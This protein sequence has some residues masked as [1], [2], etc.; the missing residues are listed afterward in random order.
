MDKKTINKRLQEVRRLCEE[1]KNDEIYLRAM[2]LKKD[3][4]YLMVD[5]TALRQTLQDIKLTF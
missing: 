5:V 2:Y 1:I 3:V 4:D